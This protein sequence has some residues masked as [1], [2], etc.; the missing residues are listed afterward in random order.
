MD[1]QLSAAMTQMEIGPWPE[2]SALDV[3]DEVL[4]AARIEHMVHVGEVETAIANRPVS[5]SH[6]NAKSK[7]AP[8]SLRDRAQQERDATGIFVEPPALTHQRVVPWY[9]QG[10]YVTPMAELPPGLPL[11]QLPRPLSA[12]APYV[13]PREGAPHGADGSAMLEDEEVEV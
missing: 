2:D 4:E 8:R 11:G 12:P 3:V 13:A 9:R 7:S 1:E 5:S 10:P 6:A